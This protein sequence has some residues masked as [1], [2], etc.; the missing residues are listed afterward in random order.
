RQWY[1]TWLNKN[2]RQY[3]FYAAQR[4]DRFVTNSQVVAKR[5]RKFYRRAVEVIPPP[6]TVQGRGEAGGQY[7]LYVGPLTRDQQV[8]LAVDAC[9]QLNL[10]LWVVGAGN[11]MERLQRI[12]GPTIRFLGAVPEAERVQLYAQAKALLFPCS[13]AD[14]AI[15][16]V[17]AMGAGI[18]VI[19]SKLSGMREVILDYRTGLLFEEATVES[20]R[21]AIAKF[22]SLRFSSQACIERAEEFAESVF[23]SKL[24]WFIAQSLDDHRLVPPINS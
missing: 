8:D 6:V 18:P 16:P 19:A 15:T 14:F 13:H 22:E 2:L 21:G 4:V 20:L 1:T 9:T 7:Y 24:E 3:D 11:D 5:M 23:A 17:E 12:A 10:P